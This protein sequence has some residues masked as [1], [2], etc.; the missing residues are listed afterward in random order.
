MLCRPRQFVLNLL[1]LAAFLIVI[2]GLANSLFGF[3]RIGLVIVFLVPHIA[4]RLE[5][6]HA[7]HT[8]GL[9]PGK[10]AMWHVSRQMTSIY[11]QIVALI[12]LLFVA[13]ISGSSD[14]PDVLSPIAVFAIGMLCTVF[15]GAVL[16]VVRAGYWAGVRNGEKSV[17]RGG[18]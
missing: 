16:L 11:V 1:G 15:Y 5:G 2:G 4:A 10:Q 18:I 17:R 3:G 12:L 13:P 9:R 7:V 6:Q 14:T 8:H